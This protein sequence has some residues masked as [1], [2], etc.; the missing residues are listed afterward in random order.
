MVFPLFP[1]PR[2]PEGKIPLG[3][4]GHR[5]EYNIIM[6]LREVSWEC[7]DLSHLAQDWE[8]WWPLV[9]MVLNLQVP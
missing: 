5:C 2:Q 4:P 1:S 7:M 3:R 8:Q 6:D 9:N